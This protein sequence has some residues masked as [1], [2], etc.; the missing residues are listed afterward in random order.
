MSEYT[1]NG[2]ISRLLGS[3]PG[4]GSEKG[5]LTEKVYERPFSMIL[6]DEFEKAHPEV[7]DLFLQ[8]FEEG[9]LTD[10]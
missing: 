1:G 7:L 4:Q 10:N 5:E 6:L 3:A 9:R 8:V 2:A